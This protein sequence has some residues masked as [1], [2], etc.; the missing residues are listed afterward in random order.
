MSHKP[1]SDQPVS[2]KFGTFKKIISG[3]RPAL[4]E[5]LSTLRSRTTFRTAAGVP[6]LNV[7]G[8]RA[9]KEREVGA[10]VKRVLETACLQA[11]LPDPRIL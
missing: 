11:P 3:V 5:R 6:T 4:T 7:A 10:F 1:G 9:S 2:H 8:P